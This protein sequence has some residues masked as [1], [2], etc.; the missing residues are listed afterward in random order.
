[1]EPD[2]PQPMGACPTPLRPAHLRDLLTRFCGYA[3]PGDRSSLPIRGAIHSYI[4]TSLHPCTPIPIHPYTPIPLYPY[5]HTSIH[6]YI[7]ASLHLLP[8]PG[9]LYHNIGWVD[10]FPEYFCW[11]GGNEHTTAVDICT[12]IRCMTVEPVTPPYPPLGIVIYTARFL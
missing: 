3:Q 2:I 6:P 9:C 7:P 10:M 11:L 12:D 5:T 1:M 8:I 4:H